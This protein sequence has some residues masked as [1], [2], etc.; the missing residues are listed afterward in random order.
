MTRD[1]ILQSLLDVGLIDSEYVDEVKK[2]V[3]ASADANILIGALRADLQDVRPSDL[4]FAIGI[5]LTELKSIPMVSSLSAVDPREDAGPGFLDPVALGESFAEGL[6]D[7]EAGI[8]TIPGSLAELLDGGDGE[9]FDE[10]AIG[11]AL[12]DVYKELKERGD[13]TPTE[14]QELYAVV[15]GGVKSRRDI[16]NAVKK[17]RLA[18]ATSEDLGEYS[19]FPLTQ[20]GDVAAEGEY[21]GQDRRTTYTPQGVGADIEAQAA[22]ESQGWGEFDSF[23]SLTE[24]MGMATQERPPLLDT[25]KQ[26]TTGLMIDFG[27]GQLVDY[28]FPDPIGPGPDA[29]M[30]RATGAV[31]TNEMYNLIRTDA[32][33]R[34][35]YQELGKPTEAIN[36]LLESGKFN[37]PGRTQLGKNYIP[38]ED[39]GVPSVAP[40]RPWETQAYNWSQGSGAAQ[41]GSMAAYSRR[42]KVKYMIDS[43]VATPEQAA[44]YSNPF[45]LS[46]AQQWGRVLGVSRE[47]QVA[48]YEAMNSMGAEISRI[49]S[50]VNR[51]GGG[52]GGGSSGPTYSVPASLREIPDYKTLAER[53]KG[54]FQQELGRDMEDWEL[55]ALADE[56]K[57]KYVQANRDRI[58]IHKAAWDDAV[59]GGSTDVDFTEVEEP[60]EGLEFDIGEKYEDELARYDRVEDRASN[61]MLL[62]DSIAVGERMV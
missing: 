20:E 45:S 1:E 44:D 2:K 60:T 36:E 6:G 24:A 38:V 53:T 52:Y 22:V 13:L 21:L 12:T 39:I 57:D 54:I 30:D 11:M 50:L 3:S 61:R 7:V 29:I 33:L 23:R 58:Q 4:A 28:N 19:D 55:S 46:G 40:S 62:M 42:A 27:E 34:K 18:G 48:P 31:L 8:N 59:S 35:R 5:P 14:Q 32:A 15:A 51:S 37:V 43:G 26:T 16:E 10:F 41:W 47:L 49:R 25:E 56:L 9:D 17:L